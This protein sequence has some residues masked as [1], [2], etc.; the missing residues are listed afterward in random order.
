MAKKAKAEETVEVAP[1]RRV[2]IVLRWFSQGSHNKSFG[3]KRKIEECLSE[4][5][6]NAYNMDQKSFAIT[7]KLELERQADS[8]R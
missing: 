5:I 7:K 1:Q 2:D 8:S 6:I 3:K 4:E